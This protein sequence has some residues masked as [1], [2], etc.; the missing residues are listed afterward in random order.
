MLVGGLAISQAWGGGPDISHVG[1]TDISSH[2]GGSDD[3]SSL[4][5]LDTSIKIILRKSRNNSDTDSVP[6]SLREKYND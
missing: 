5:S 3:I 1:G 6:L 2:A 4:E